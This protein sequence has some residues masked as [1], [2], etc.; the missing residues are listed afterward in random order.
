M[1]SLRE[2]QLQVKTFRDERDWKQ[3][4]NFKDMLLS[5]GLEVSEF[6]ELFQWK[7]DSEVKNLPRE[8]FGEELADILYWVLLF[9]EDLDID[10]EQAFGNKMLKN[11]GKYPV[12][13]ARGKKEKYTSYK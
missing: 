8:S 13:Q 12:D 9:A 3:F 10:L 6:S 1:S 2:L 7:S 4:H 11:E 5:L